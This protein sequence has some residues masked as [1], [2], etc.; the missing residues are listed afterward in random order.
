M[1]ITIRSYGS[2]DIAAMNKIWNGIVKQGNAFP[3]TELLDEINGETFFGS[4]TYCGVAENTESNEI[5]GLYI[6]HTN[7]VDRCSHIANAS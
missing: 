1:S 5:T 4:Q 6:L 3:Q 7:N 2:E